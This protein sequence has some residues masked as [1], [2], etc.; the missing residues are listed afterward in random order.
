[1]AGAGI[2]L[3]VFVYGMRWLGYHEFLEAS[4]SLRSVVRNARAI[5]RDKILARDVAAL[6]QRASDFEELAAVLRQS[7]VVFHF[8]NIEVCLDSEPIPSL[9]S[10]ATPAQT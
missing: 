5:V 8:R 4:T 10:L 7:A 2:L 6:I 3:F 1:S 9:R